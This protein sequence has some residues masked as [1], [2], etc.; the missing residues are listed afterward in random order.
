M[1][2][3]TKDL[4]LIISDLY[5]YTNYSIQVLAF[6]E[7]GDGVRSDPIY[8]NTPQA[9]ERVNCWNTRNH[10]KTQICS[11]MVRSISF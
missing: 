5:I 2:L 3:Q 7:F 10:E 1:I 4:F 9:G 8:I 6:T 11:D